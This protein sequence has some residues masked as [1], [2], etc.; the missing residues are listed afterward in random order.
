MIALTDLVRKKSPPPSLKCRAILPTSGSRSASLW[1]ADSLESLQAWLDE[2]VD[3]D[4]A[5]DVAPV[6]EEFAVG[7]A[8]VSRARAV[9]ATAARAAAAGGKAVDAARDVAERLK[10][11][12]RAAAVGEKVGAVATAALEDERVVRARARAGAAAAGAWGWAKAAA[13]GLARGDAPGRDLP[14]PGR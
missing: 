5:H 7:L 10:V 13:S 3:M 6:Q 4:C 1:D 14:P 9:D 11:G 8:D 2:H 12:E